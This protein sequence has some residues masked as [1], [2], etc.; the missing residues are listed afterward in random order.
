MTS[1]GHGMVP[2]AFCP[3]Q[4]LSFPRLQRGVVAWAQLPFL[5]KGSCELP[6]H[7]LLGKSFSLLNHARP[8][9]HG[10]EQP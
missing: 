3:G 1:E 6:Q 10:L 5:V 4:I 2:L 7:T 9:K 8:Q